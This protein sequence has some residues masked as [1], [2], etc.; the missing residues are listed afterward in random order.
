M[1]QLKQESGVEYLK[2]TDEIKK[3]YLELKQ[4]ALDKQYLVAC[5]QIRKLKEV[6]KK[7][8]KLKEKQK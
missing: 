7:A 5:D 4:E 2:M 8:E 3:R 6:D 1:V